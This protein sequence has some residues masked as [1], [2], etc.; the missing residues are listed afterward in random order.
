MS[1]PYFQ[2]KQFT[3]WHDKCAM[4]VGTD[5]VLLGAWAPI[6]FQAKYILDVGCGSGLISLMMAQRSQAMI[7]ALDID[8]SAVQQTL[9][10]IQRSP[11]SKRIQAFQ[12]DFKTFESEHL[13]DIIVSNPPFF[14]HSL[15]CPDAVRT[16]ARHTTELTYTD[17]LREAARHLNLGGLLSF[18]VPTDAENMIQEVASEH[19]LYIHKKLNVQTKP[20]GEIKRIL[21][22]F[23]N[24]PS[25]QTVEEE[26]LLTELERHIYS[27]EYIR[28][29]SPYYLHL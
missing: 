20:N 22:C 11:W 24:V 13:F 21:F 27:P 3:I 18:I 9:E 14:N 2:F 6:T 5:G 12:A 15:Q 7:T 8:P 19:H 17:L 16:K 4:K 25:I 10:N 28:L 23:S 26:S 29:T 1:N